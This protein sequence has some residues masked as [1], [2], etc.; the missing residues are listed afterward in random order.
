[1]ISQ[2]NPFEHSSIS[3]SL[4]SRTFNSPFLNLSPSSERRLWSAMRIY[5]QV[6]LEFVPSFHLLC[7]DVGLHSLSLSRLLGH[8]GEKLGFD[9]LFLVHHHT[10][11]KESSQYKPWKMHF[12][13]T[14][15]QWYVIYTKTSSL[16]L[17]KK[18]ARF[19]ENSVRK[20]SWHCI[21][22]VKRT[23]LFASSY[24]LITKAFLF[25]ELFTTASFYLTWQ[26]LQQWQS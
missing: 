10:V 17:F 3:S 4:S 14:Q 9:T 24:K 13:F 25:H 8:P 26:S 6:G 22:H 1:M 11:F 18:S 7:N 15:R 20:R 5:I 16:T 19:Y 12:V 2:N 21:E 23:K